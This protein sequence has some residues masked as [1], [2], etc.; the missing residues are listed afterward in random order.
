MRIAIP[1]WEDKVSP[2]FDSASRLLVI[3]LENMQELSRLVYPIG[4][5]L[6]CKCR[7]IRSLCPDVII[8]GAISHLLSSMLNSMGIDVI[9][10]VS[11]RT[12]EVLEAY[13]EGDIFDSRF[14]MPGCRRKGYGRPGRGINI[15][16]SK[17][18][19]NEEE[20]Q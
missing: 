18:S 6:P 10:Q 2:V 3:D 17:K 19:I 15:R 14:L 1:I 12:E 4:E 16:K 7:K 9:P 20:I 11:G 13:L 5:D 8:C